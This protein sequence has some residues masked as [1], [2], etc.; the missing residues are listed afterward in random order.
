MVH[1]ER[2]HN[3]DG[4]ILNKTALYHNA[5]FIQ[6]ISHFQIPADGDIAFGQ[7]M[8]KPSSQYFYCIDQSSN[9]LGKILTKV[10]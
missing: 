8:A 1:Q 6:M 3:S 7:L 9:F 2:L 5:N 10:H 4:K